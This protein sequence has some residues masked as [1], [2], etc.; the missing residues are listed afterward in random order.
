M[1]LP[2]TSLCKPFQ[3]HPPLPPPQTPAPRPPLMVLDHLDVI[4]MDNEHLTICQIGDTLGGQSC[5]SAPSAITCPLPWCLLGLGDCGSLQHP[6]LQGRCYA[7]WVPLVATTFLQRLSPQPVDP[8]CRSP[9]RPPRAMTSCPSAA[10]PW[11]DAIVPLSRFSIVDYLSTVDYVPLDHRHNRTH[12]NLL[13]PVYDRPSRAR[14]V[15][16][17]TAVHAGRKLTLLPSFSFRAHQPGDSI[18]TLYASTSTSRSTRLSSS[19]RFTRILSS[20]CSGSSPV[21]APHTLRR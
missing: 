19:S 10:T 12:G 17:L 16:H 5:I 2:E 18:S 6:R 13:M 4:V 3:S 15:L 9:S 11:V 20:S 7:T 8:I 14:W 21:R 1:D